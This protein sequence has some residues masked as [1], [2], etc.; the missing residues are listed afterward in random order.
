M[1]ARPAKEGSG[2]WF[3]PVTNE[4]VMTEPR[5]RGEPQTDALRSHRAQEGSIQ[6]ILQATPTQK[7][8]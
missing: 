5:N 3:T 1:V 7:K 6:I 4:Q 2:A 8:E